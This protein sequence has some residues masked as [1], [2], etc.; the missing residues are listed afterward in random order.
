MGG[1]HGAGGI[2]FR[3]AKVAPL[4]AEAVCESLV[5]HMPLDAVH[6]AEAGRDLS[7][8]GKFS[9]RAVA[10]R[11]I[12]LHDRAALQG[13]EGFLGAKGEPGKDQQ[14]QRFLNS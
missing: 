14:S 1:Y 6:A 12:R 4:R 11:P 13:L 3:D 10:I 8:I 9:C 7:F 2:G 5:V